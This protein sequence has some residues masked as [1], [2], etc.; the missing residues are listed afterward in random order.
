VGL[1]YGR[2]Q[3]ITVKWKATSEGRMHHLPLSWLLEVAIKVGFRKF[4]ANDAL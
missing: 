3:S 2:K 1:I 4:K